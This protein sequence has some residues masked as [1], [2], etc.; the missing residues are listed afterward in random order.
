MLIKTNTQKYFNYFKCLTFKSTMLLLSRNYSRLNNMFGN[1]NR[2]FI[3]EYKY[4]SN[5]RMKFYNEIHKNIKNPLL[6]EEIEESS[7]DEEEEEIPVN[8]NKNFDSFFL[9]Y[10]DSELDSDEEIEEILEYEDNESLINEVTLAEIL[11]TKEED[12]EEIDE[13]DLTVKKLDSDLDL[14]IN[15]VTEFLN[16]L[17]ESEDEKE[18]LDEISNPYAFYQLNPKKHKDILIKTYTKAILDKSIYNNEREP[19]V[20]DLI[21]EIPFEPENIYLTK[22]LTN[23]LKI[24][25]IENFD[26]LFNKFYFKH[27]SIFGIEVEDKSVKVNLPFYEKLV[28]F[29]KDNQLILYRDDDYFTP[30]FLI[31]LIN[32]KFNYIIETDEHLYDYYEIPYDFYDQL[33]NDLLQRE[34]IELSRNSINFTEYEFD[35]DS[36]VFLFKSLLD[37]GLKNNLYCNNLLK[38][39]YKFLLKKKKSI[40]KTLKKK[41]LQYKVFNID[42]IKTK[43]CNLK[44]KKKPL[45][46][47][48]IRE[49]LNEDEIEDILVED[50]EIKENFYFHY[51]L[52]FELFNFINILFFL[53]NSDFNLN[54]YLTINLKENKQI[55]YLISELYFTDNFPSD[56]ADDFEE[57]LNIITSNPLEFLDYIYSFLSFEMELFKQYLLYFRKHFYYI[58][59]HLKNFKYSLLKNT[60]FYN[61]IDY[62]IKSNVIKFKEDLTLLKMFMFEVYIHPLEKELK[63][64]NDKIYEVTDTMSDMLFFNPDREQYDLN[65]VFQYKHKVVLLINQNLKKFEL[66]KTVAIEVFKSK[67]NYSIEYCKL[68]FLTIFKNMKN[69]ARRAEMF[70]D[71]ILILINYLKE[72]DL[73][74][75]YNDL[76]KK[77]VEKQY[78]V[79]EILNQIK[80]QDNLYLKKLEE[81]E[82]RLAKIKEDR[83]KFELKIK[84]FPKKKESKMEDLEEL[85]FLESNEEEDS[86]NGVSD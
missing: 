54:N 51:S 72:N 55:L 13:N 21:K 70:S 16:E 58:L 24:K 52:S 27:M 86:S 69:I 49:I 79:E 25:D 84:E 31:D 17:D 67:W 71:F 75:Y 35:C 15:E 57:F 46:L 11:F 12:E 2:S 47:L 42:Y 32:L 64:Y 60:Y 65:Y 3:D 30:Q 73:V 76:Y 63:N 1:E 20:Y 81:E 19:I 68:H 48:N 9:E 78:D 33:S 43:V 38:K 41:K 66:A 14:A 4:F 28:M 80:S 45:N 5:H 85:N 8:L 23:N 74:K 36:T 83:K 34:G 10:L 26:R 6:D 61:L 59:K 77:E 40:K 82:K 62:R 53:E 50:Y 56:E 7:S 22:Y 37:Y 18:E 29:K 39:L 44:K